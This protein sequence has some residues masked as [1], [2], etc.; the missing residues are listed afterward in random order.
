MNTA[1][2]Q[3]LPEA[4]SRK[5]IWMRG[6]Y[7]L[8]FILALGIAQPVLNLIAIVQ[9]LSLMIFRE[10]NKHLAAFGSSLGKWLEQMAAFQSGNTEDKPFPWNDWPKAN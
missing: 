1:T 8:F 3:T 10:A 4:E 9:F 2:E 5:P 7:M 6:L